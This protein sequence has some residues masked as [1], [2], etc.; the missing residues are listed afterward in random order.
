[1]GMLHGVVIGGFMVDMAYKHLPEG[2]LLDAFCE[3]EKCLP[4]AIQLLTPCTMGNGWLKVNNI[5]RFA[6]TC[7]IKIAERA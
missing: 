1:M 2:V 7:T 3:T 4:D 6:L 5:G